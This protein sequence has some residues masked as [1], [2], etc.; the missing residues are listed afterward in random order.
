MNEEI[1][2]MDYW[3]EILEKGYLDKGYIERVIRCNLKEILLGNEAFECI[4]EI[5]NER[6]M[7]RV[8]YNKI[9]NSD[10]DRMILF[11]I[12]S[13]NKTRRDIN[14]C[15][16]IIRNRGTKRN[17]IDNIQVFDKSPLVI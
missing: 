17:K 2:E 5:N 4:Q 9:C 13:I 14:Y 15:A 3:T 6:V 7:L 1:D 10:N 16:C 12:I 11:C 8:I